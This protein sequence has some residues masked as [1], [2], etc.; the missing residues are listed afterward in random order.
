[1]KRVSASSMLTS[2]NQDMKDMIEEVLMYAKITHKNV[3]TDCIRCRQGERF[4]Q[5]KFAI[6]FAELCK[7][8]P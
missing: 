3:E 6:S 1:M 2:Y 8:V 5:L 4:V 7:Y